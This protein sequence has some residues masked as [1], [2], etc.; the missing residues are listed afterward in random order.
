MI[1]KDIVN[2]YIMQHKNVG[3]RRWLL[4]VWAAK[5]QFGLIRFYY[6]FVH[7]FVY[8]IIFR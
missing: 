3:V 6:R 7:K 4:Q 2:S 1:R 5:G 8:G